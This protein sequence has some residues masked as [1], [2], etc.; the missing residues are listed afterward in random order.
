[1]SANIYKTVE[2]PTRFW[3]FPLPYASRH[4]EILDNM[5]NAGWELAATTTVGVNNFVEK[6]I[7]TFKKPGSSQ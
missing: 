7:L 6:L 4:Q 1:M 2:I 5:A 3:M